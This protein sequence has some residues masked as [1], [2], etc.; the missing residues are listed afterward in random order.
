[1]HQISIWYSLGGGV[2]HNGLFLL[3]QKTF[4]LWVIILHH[5]PTQL[6][7]ICKNPKEC[8]KFVPK[9][10][11]WA[12]SHTTPINPASQAC[13]ASSVHHVYTPRRCRQAHPSSSPQLRWLSLQILRWLKCVPF[14]Q[15]NCISFILPG[16]FPSPLKSFSDV[17]S[18]Q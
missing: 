5:F 4:N 7:V 1:M 11:R 9:M 2:F 13:V 15:L 14:H 17:Y 12:H 18:C 3:L 16:S 10:S 6:Q 8:P